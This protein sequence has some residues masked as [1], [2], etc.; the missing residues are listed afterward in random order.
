MLV[1]KFGQVVDIFIN[2]NVEVIGLVMRRY[3]T[4]G[5]DLR[6]DGEDATAIY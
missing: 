3:V 2:D 6:H 1:L 5:E 4:R